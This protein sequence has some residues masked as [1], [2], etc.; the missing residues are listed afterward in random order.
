MVYQKQYQPNEVKKT[1]CPR[2]LGS[3]FLTTGSKRTC[4][5]CGYLMEKTFNKFGARKQQYKGTIYDSKFEAGTAEYLDMQLSSG[6]VKNVLK[7]VK[8]PLFAYEVKIFNYIIDFVVIHHDGHKEYVE[9]KG[10]E[11]DLWKA[12]WK[13]LEAK[14][15]IEEPDS[16]MT[17]LKQGNMP[18][19]RKR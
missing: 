3:Q 2:C 17:L 4:H 16:V 19:R 15:A 14:L 1:K 9:A 10:Y 18:K 5:N 11:T 6:Q 12:K 13:M 8:I 7:Q